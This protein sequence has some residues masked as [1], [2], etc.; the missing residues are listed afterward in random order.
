MYRE[1]RAPSSIETWIMFRNFGALQ[2]TL[3]ETSRIPSFRPL[4]DF[5]KFWAFVYMKSSVL[6][7][8]RFR[9]FR[10]PIGT[11]EEFGTY[12]SV[13][14]WKI[15][16]SSVHSSIRTWRI[17][18]PLYAIHEIDRHETCSIFCAHRKFLNTLTMFPRE[19]D[20]IKQS[21]LGYWSW[22]WWSF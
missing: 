20:N 13:W 10:A 7:L 21:F 5:G 9:E 14:N 4:W 18:A 19:F 2:C 16:C 1:F 12:N 3:I 8:E 22:K 15:F 11:L 6:G 17:R